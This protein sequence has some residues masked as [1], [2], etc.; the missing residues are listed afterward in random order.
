MTRSQ[1]RRRVS[2]A[3]SALNLRLALAT[4]G[5]VTM[6]VFAVVAFWAHVAWLGVLCAVLA[7]VAVVD[8]IVIQRRRA[9]RHREEPGVRHSLFE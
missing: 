9:A 7:V 5:L 4:F 6:T 3:Y 1:P 2:N 8:L